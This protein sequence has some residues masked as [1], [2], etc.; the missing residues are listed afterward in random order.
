[1]C[2]W[3]MDS[4][5]Y[6]SFR[7]LFIPLPCDLMFCYLRCKQ[8]LNCNCIMNKTMLIKGYLSVAMCLPK[9]LNTFFTSPMVGFA[10]ISCQW[11]GVEFSAEIPS[12][13]IL[14]SR[15]TVYTCCRL[16]FI[17]CFMFP[18]QDIYRCRQINIL[19]FLCLDLGI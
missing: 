6:I 8:L 9:V 4:D 18:S 3:P 10:I 2:T 11:I 7:S 15:K 13:T 17:I 19:Y 5:I 16:S 12:N 1:M 14:W